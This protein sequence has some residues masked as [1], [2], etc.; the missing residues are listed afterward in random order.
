MMLLHK[1]GEG[2]GESASAEGERI[3]ITMLDA[4]R[5]WYG[6]TGVG[7]GEVNGKLTI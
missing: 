1:H 6:Q 7:R 3:T 2:R 4:T 5:N